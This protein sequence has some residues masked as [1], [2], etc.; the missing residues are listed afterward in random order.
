[1]TEEFFDAKYHDP[2]YVSKLDRNTLEK[3]GVTLDNDEC[4]STRFV[5]GIRFREQFIPLVFCID[6]DNKSCD[7]G[8]MPLWHNRP[9][10]IRCPVCEYIYFPL[11]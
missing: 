6:C 5:D 1:M 7:M 3:L 2:I 9:L 11:S 10:M 4:Y 8:P